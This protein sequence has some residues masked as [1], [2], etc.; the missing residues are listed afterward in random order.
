MLSVTANAHLKSKTYDAEN[1][2]DTH[3]MS[4]LEPEFIV[5]PTHVSGS[6]AS[7]ECKCKQ[8]CKSIPNGGGSV[9]IK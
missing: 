7:E 5:I 8:T 3:M 4:H 6:E 9:Y 1:S 2:E